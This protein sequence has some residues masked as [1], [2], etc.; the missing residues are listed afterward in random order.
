MNTTVAN[1]SDENS[2]NKKAYQSPQLLTY[3]DIREITQAVGESKTLDG[4]GD[5]MDK[6]QP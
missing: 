5:P 3:G 4:G 1:R 2:A 6:T